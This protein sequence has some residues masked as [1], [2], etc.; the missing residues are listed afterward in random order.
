M[1]DPSAEEFLLSGD[2]ASNV[3]DT[4]LRSPVPSNRLGEFV[5]GILS[6]AARDDVRVFAILLV[7]GGAVLA[8]V[9][10]LCFLA[11]GSFC[12]SSAGDSVASGLVGADIRG[13]LFGGCG[14]API[15]STL[16]PCGVVGAVVLPDA[17]GLCCFF[18]GLSVGRDDV[19]TV[20]AVDGVGTKE[21]PEPR[22]EF[23]D[24]AELTEDL[25]VLGIG[26]EGRGPVGGPY[27]GREC[28]GRGS[29]DVVA[30]FASI[31]A[32]EMERRQP[33]C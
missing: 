12:I 21:L 16:S 7:R 32:R 28:P 8:P 29:V 20:R 13:P 33:L 9:E 2:G 26:S 3:L 25:R 19:E 22:R 6:D 5:F 14:K 1:Y 17:L 4:D 31:N 23:A 27:D 10:F 15:L 30:I 24:V 11:T 18:G